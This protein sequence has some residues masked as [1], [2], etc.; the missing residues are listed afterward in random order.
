[1]LRVETRLS[2]VC[3]NGLKCRHIFYSGQPGEF[4]FFGET[5]ALAAQLA[6]KAGW[7]VWFGKEEVICPTCNKP[8]E[9]K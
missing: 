2:L 1:M 5:A 3:D 6:R 4:V 7:I 8:K 9:T